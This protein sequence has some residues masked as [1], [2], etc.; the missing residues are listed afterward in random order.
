[1][2]MTLH[3]PNCCAGLLPGDKNIV[4]QADSKGGGQKK[5]I[6]HLPVCHRHHCVEAAAS[7][8]PSPH[9]TTLQHPTPISPT[10]TT[11]P[12][13]PLLLLLFAGGRAEGEEGEGDAA[14]HALLSKHV[15]RVAGGE[16]V[17]LLY[18]WVSVCLRSNFP[19]SC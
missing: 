4:V 12:A 10:P 15:A 17:D 1:M 7:I 18:R 19:Q 3:D 16:A 14:T 8:N 9:A 2:L 11:P 6:P 13:H 5:A